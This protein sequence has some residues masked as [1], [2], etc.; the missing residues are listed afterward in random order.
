MCEWPN[1]LISPPGL[2]SFLADHPMSCWRTPW[3]S[4]YRRTPGP[5]CDQLLPLAELNHQ[6]PIKR[7]FRASWS[8]N[9]RAISRL[10]ERWLERIEQKR[11]IALKHSKISVATPMSGPKAVISSMV[12]VRRWSFIFE[13]IFVESRAANASRTFATAVFKSSLN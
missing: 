9:W 12:W 3:S 4:K 1:R 2:R 10:G 11:K 8:A 6:P 7:C 5:A 13:M